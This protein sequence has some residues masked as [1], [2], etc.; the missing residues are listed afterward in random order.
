MRA[1]IPLESGRPLCMELE[2]MSR[3]L[4]FMQWNLTHVMAEVLEP[5]R[6]TQGSSVNCFK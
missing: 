5:L 3:T 6:I 4:R 2:G 1:D